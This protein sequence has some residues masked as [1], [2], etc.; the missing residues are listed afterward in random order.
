[1]QG[2]SR[3]MRSMSTSPPTRMTFTSLSQATAAD[4]TIISAA[5]SRHRERAGSGARLNVAPRLD[6]H[7]QQPQHVIRIDRLGGVMIETG[8]ENVAAIA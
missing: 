8:L 2:H 3:Q 1:M 6:R 4:W 5:E 7:E